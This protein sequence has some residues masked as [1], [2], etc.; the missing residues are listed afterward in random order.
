[1]FRVRAASFFTGF[2]VA[3]GIAMFQLQRDVWGSHHILADEAER[4][5]SQL[6]KR[7]QHLER[8]TGVGAPSSQPTQVSSLT[9]AFGKCDILGVSI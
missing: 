7:I 4:Y 8:V 1:M 6:E 3:S 9:T 5:Y 2:A